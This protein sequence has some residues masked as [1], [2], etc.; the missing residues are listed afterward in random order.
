MTSRD[1]VFLVYSRRHDTNS[2][3]AAYLENATTL[4]GR[5]FVYGFKEGFPFDDGR[6]V[7]HFLRTLLTLVRARR[8]QKS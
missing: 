2:D 8:C 1:T 4:V 3:Y 7:D 6:Q 5:I